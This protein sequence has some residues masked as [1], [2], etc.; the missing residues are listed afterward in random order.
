MLLKA[1]CKL[2]NPLLKIPKARNSILIKGG[3]VVNADRQFK[4]D[5]KIENGKV[6]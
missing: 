3:T 5:V 1:A 4:A 2:R 6:S